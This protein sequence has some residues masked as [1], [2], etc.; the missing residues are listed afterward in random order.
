MTDS[1][2]LLP[3]TGSDH[4]LRRRAIAGVRGDVESLG[5]GG[6]LVR[7]PGL[8][9]AVV[10]ATP[11]RSIF[12]A[13]HYTDPAALRTQIDEIEGAYEAAG[14][15]AWTVW[16]PDEDRETASLLESRGHALDGAPRAMALWLED[17]AAGPPQ[18]EGLEPCEGSIA[19]AGEINDR[20]YGIEGDGFAAALAGAQFHPSHWSFAALDGEKVACL[21]TVPL[22]DGDVLVSGVATL[23]DWRG[24]GIAGWLLRRAL[25]ARRAEGFESASL[26]ASALGAGVYEALGF[27]DLGHVELWE[28][29]AS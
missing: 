9:A 21:E 8:V 5:S 6:E 4:E 16:V 15:E 1:D 23:P 12:N 10:P 13:V 3:S 28:K 2:D 18:V 22:D 7:W 20:A 25:A 17:L 14:V 26:R 29:R 11:H 27:Q 19:D 24:R